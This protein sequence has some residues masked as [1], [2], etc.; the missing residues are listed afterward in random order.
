MNF[1]REIGKRV[2]DSLQI[3]GAIHSEIPTEDLTV[4]LHL[5][6]LP[7]K[8]F[9]RAVYQGV[10]YQSMRYTRSTKRNNY[11]VLYDENKA[12]FIAY[13]LEVDIGPSKEYYA[14]IQ[15]LVPD[16]HPFILSDLNEI[17]IKLEHMLC[18]KKTRLA[19][20]VFLLP[21]GA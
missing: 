4:L 20:Y 14:L 5:T 7:T 2:S 17:N 8:I 9:C 21:A 13:F 16:E 12:G 18:F 3:L 1:T 6:N 15:P 11:T 19:F 10:Q